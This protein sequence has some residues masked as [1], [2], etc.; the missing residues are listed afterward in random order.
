M[1]E[2]LTEHVLVNPV[3]HDRMI[4][5]K[6]CDQARYLILPLTHPESYAIALQLQGKVSHRPLTHDLMKNLVETM[7]ATVVRVV[8]SEF[9]D[10]TFYAQVVLDVAGTEKTS[11]ARASD[12]LALALHTKAPVFVTEPVFELKGIPV[13]QGGPL[14]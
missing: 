1:I 13:D 7:G 3:T 11:D 14:P 6:A 9:S 12:A 10:D 2:L 4:P 8:I 5:L